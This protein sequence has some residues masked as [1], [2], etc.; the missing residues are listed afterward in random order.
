MI[1]MDAF[2]ESISPLKLGLWDPHRSANKKS[3]SLNT[4]QPSQ[5]IL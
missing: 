4:F 5:N 2:E 1:I 3:P